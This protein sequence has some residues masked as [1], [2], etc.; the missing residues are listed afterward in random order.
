MWQAGQE[1]FYIKFP[2]GMKR[3]GF[4]SDKKLFA[5]SFLL[6]RNAMVSGTIGNP[7]KTVSYR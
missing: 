5:N 7:S 4:K 1:T 3:N 6:V 2:V